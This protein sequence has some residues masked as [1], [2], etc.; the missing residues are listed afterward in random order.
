MKIILEPKGNTRCEG[1]SHKCA[2]GYARLHM[3]RST[4]IAAVLV[5]IQLVVLRDI[6]VLIK[7][8]ALRHFDSQRSALR[9]EYF[10]KKKKKTHG[11]PVLLLI[12]RTFSR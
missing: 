1:Q 8:V 7:R 6:K 5:T 3:G 12:E 9:G 10:Q 11:I 2:D 4:D